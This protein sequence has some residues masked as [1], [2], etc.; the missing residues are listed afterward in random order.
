ME[1]LEL[2]AEARQ[3]VKKHAKD[4]RQRGLVPAVIYGGDI[5]TQAIQVDAVALDKVLSVAGTH[6]L[7][8]LQVGNQKPHFTM[9]RDIQRDVVKRHYLHVDFY[10][11]KMDRKVHTEIPLVLV[12]QAPGVAD[13][14]GILTQGLD[15]LEAECLPSDLI[16]SIEV[17][18]ESL[19][20]F[21]D[22]I[23]VADLNVPSTITVLSDPESMV[24]KIEPPRKL[25]ALEEEE[26]AEEVS[27]EPEVITEAREDK[28]EE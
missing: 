28:D 10:A 4:L 1:A 11:V 21:N 6:Q 20:D 8:A 17:N 3:V 22:T 15:L 13:K 9:A 23:T 26:A 19:V 16:P 18:V 27:A 14:G 2:K 25:E 12:G 5:E 24:A 7:I